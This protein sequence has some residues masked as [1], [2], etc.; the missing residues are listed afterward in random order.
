M[1]IT[2]ALSD[3]DLLAKMKNF[4]DHLVERKTEG[5]HKDWV[6][7]AVAFANSAPTGVPAVLYI[8]VKDNGEIETPQVN[9]ENIQKKFNTR[10]KAVYPRIFCVPKIVSENG[11]EALAV[12]IP[13]SEQRPHFAGLSYIRKGTETIEASEEQFAALIAQRNSKAALILKSK[14]QQIT[15]L[16]RTA[17]IGG[18]YSE[19]QWPSST[20]LVDCNQF[21]V[22]LQ[23]G[24]T[25]PV[26]SFPLS[27]VE[28]NFDSSLSRLQ[29]EILR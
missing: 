1:E 28:I 10:M 18:G 12:I 8:G 9:L 11:L 21:Y 7:T 29:L 5:D 16:N 19:T 27:R 17:T 25:Q 15:V 20:V 22:T 4:E 6:T 3:A 23:S 2:V 24:S 14:G 13:G 26:S